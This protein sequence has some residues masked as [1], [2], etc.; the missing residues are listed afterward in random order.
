MA[1]EKKLY[2]SND[3]LVAG[4][5]AG[6]A[7][8]FDIDA[9]ATR[10]LAVFLTIS[11]F[12]AALLVYAVLAL[13]LSGHSVVLPET[14]PCAAVAASGDQDC[15]CGECAGKTRWLRRK[16]FSPDVARICVTAGIA[17][18]MLV[19]IVVLDRVVDN[20]AWY[21]LWPLG[22]VAAGLALMVIPPSRA[23]W[24]RHVALGVALFTPGMLLL[25]MSVDVLSWETLAL[26]SFRLWPGVLVVIGLEIIGRAVHNDLFILAAALCVVFMCF[27]AVTVFAQPGGAEKIVAEGIL[28]GTRGLHVLT[29]WV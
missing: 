26:A 20:I 12:G 17:V 19:A 1:V 15:A 25:L 3:A 21:Q 24:M 6:I 22:V 23:S 9:A 16:T 5:C 4:V 2:R 7:E 28:G 18:I 8:Y 10:I 11:T 13:V 29:S 14:V 27:L